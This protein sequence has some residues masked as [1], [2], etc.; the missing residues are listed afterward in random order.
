MRIN[1]QSETLDK[2][3]QF[4]K[5][6]TIHKTTTSLVREAVRQYYFKVR[7]EKKESLKEQLRELEK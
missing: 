6:N 4:I 5:D 1:L 7:E 3:C 2:H